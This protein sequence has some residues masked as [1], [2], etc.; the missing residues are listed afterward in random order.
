MEHKPLQLNIGSF[1]LV[2]GWGLLHVI[3]IHMTSYYDP[4]GSVFLSALFFWLKMISAGVVPMFWVISGYSFRET[5]LKKLLAECWHGFILPYL[6]VMVGYM[7]LYPTVMMV[8]YKSW[9]NAV[10]ESLRFTLA[11]VLGLSREGFPVLGFSLRSC[12]AAWFFLAS[13]WAITALN[14]IMKI[15][16]RRLQA[17][18][19]MLCFLLGRLLIREN[20]FYF[21]IP[22]G[23]IAVPFCYCGCLIQRYNLLERL[24]RSSRLILVLLAVSVLEGLFGYCNIASG[25]MKNYWLDLPAAG[26]MGLLF[27]LLGL[28]AG[29]REFRAGGLLRQMGLYSYWLLALHSV[30]M[31]GIPWVLWSQKL[32]QQQALAYVLELLFRGLILG[33]GCLILKRLTRIRYKRKLRAQLLARTAS[34]HP[35]SAQNPKLEETNVKKSGTKLNLS[36]F[37]LLKGFAIFCILIVHPLSYYNLD[38]MPILK[39]PITLI[40]MA[41]RGM[42]PMFFIVSGF[43][44]KPTAAKKLLKKTFSSLIKPYLW[45]M[46]GYAVVYPVVMVALYTSVSNAFHETMRYILAFLLGT[47]IEGMPFLGYTL[48]F[49][50]ASWFF[51]AMFVALNLLNLIL[52]VKKAALQ[53]LLVLTCV[54]GGYL[55][56][57]WEYM[58]Y[59]YY[60]IPQGMMATGFCYLGY[61]LKH[62]SDLHKL[63]TTIW[64]YPVLLLITVIEVKWGYFDLAYM[65]YRNVVLDYIGISCF[66]L[67][68]VMIGYLLGKREP[69]GL[70]WLSRIGTY[71]YWIISVHSVDMMAL[72]WVVWSSLMAEHQQLAFVIEFIMRAILLNLACATIKEIT[73]YRY[74]RRMLRNAR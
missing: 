35:T 15:R 37:D 38:A 59:C 45:V 29:L 12:S 72:P 22:Q 13:T 71:S 6:W 53:G 52:K 48:R 64:L 20:F 66:G 70:Q 74:Q 2:K 43:W 44:F 28:R 8:L 69:R 3:L 30:E 7:L 49:C 32:P 10:Q 27:I 54:A 5:S 19:V 68:L 46:V 9:P 60:C 4:S 21:C 26:C 1:N 23:L 14:L 42:M 73:K 25:D 41:G 61:L 40:R 65:I 31:M 55:L 33:A 39:Y 58:H 24:L 50:S 34:P 56:A 17:L 51:L 62:H 36:S 57:Q 63:A 47:A 67:L 16:N 18:P 11:F